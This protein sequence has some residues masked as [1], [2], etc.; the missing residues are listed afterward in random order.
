MAIKLG[1]IGTGGW[2]TMMHRPIL[3]RLEQAGSCT[4]NAICS[5]DEISLK[6][7]QKGF[8]HAKIYTTTNSMLCNEDLDGIILLVPPSVTPKLITQLV[9]YGKPFLT[10]KPPA[11]NSEQQKLL[12][13]EIGDLAHLVAYNRRFSPL[14]LLVQEELQTMDLQSIHVLF[15]RRNRFEK[16]FSSTFVHGLD[17]IQYFSNSDFDNVHITNQKI[18]DVKNCFIQGKMANGIVIQA[19]AQPNTTLSWERYILQGRSKTLVLK[20]PHTGVVDQPGELRIY[21]ENNLAKTIRGDELGYDKED[22]EGLSGIL[23]EHEAFLNLINGESASISTLQTS[24]STQKV[25]EI[26]LSKL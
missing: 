10:E 3:Q 15:S 1:V 9:K 11:E 23:G 14:S 18:A 12:I 8:R 25:R 26:I 22:I 17:A 21:Q 5:E 19:S 6:S 7:Y 13:Q 16:D 2:S 24:L 20:F 4:V